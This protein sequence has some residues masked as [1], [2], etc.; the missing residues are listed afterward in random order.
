MSI[1]ITN[2]ITLKSTLIFWSVVATAGM[3]GQQ[4][5]A[6][7]FTNAM[8]KGKPMIDFRLR[9][10]MVD[11]DGKDDKANALTA[12]TRLG[13]ISGS[14]Y[15]LKG[16]FEFEN[17]TSFQDD[18]DSKTNFKTSYP[19]VADPEGSEVNQAYVM[20]AAKGVT[21]KAGRQRII[22]DGARF[23]GN[24]GWRQNEQTYDAV[25]LQ[26]KQSNNMTATYSFIDGVNG[27]LGGSPSK[28]DS[29]LFNVSYKAPANIKFVAY[30]YLLDMESG[31]D[32]KTLGASAKGSWKINPS[33]KAL[34]SIEYAKMSDYADNDS[35]ESANY[36]NA[37]GGIKLRSTA[38]KLGY[39]VLGGDGATSFSTPLATK[40]KY[41]GWADKFLK[42]P[43][44]GLVD[45]YV[46]G[47]TKVSG[48]KL[49]AVFHTYSSDNGDSDYGSE[50]NLLAV[51]KFGKHYSAG[52]KYAN[53][54]ATDL[55]T[56]TT[57]LWLWGGIKF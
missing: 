33:M 21:A 31:S 52:V 2:V 56:D 32:N 7:E 11:Q 55:A 18:Y 3:L 30:G 54:M 17:T 24:V 40:H 35:G 28:M 26:L 12:R 5:L 34:Y 39:E 53:Y 47:A 46:M 22:L 41:N 43:D 50:L 36:I 4:S 14:M 6:N 37:E 15:G 27:I 8:A 51:K 1:K 20:Y 16:F 38:I 44:D 23:V 13:F 19:V 48:T 57:K 25:L 9:S 42:T 45:I 49:L 29:H 10:E